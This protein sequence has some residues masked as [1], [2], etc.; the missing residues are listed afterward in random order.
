MAH[1]KPIVASDLEVL[2]EVLVHDYNALLVPC[3]D[4][5]SW[6]RAIELLVEDASLRRKLASNA[7]DD[8]MHKFCWDQR[9]KVI[10]DNVI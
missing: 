10:L 6:C 8:L 9:C 3:D 1:K 7:Y 4:V 2:R 5:D